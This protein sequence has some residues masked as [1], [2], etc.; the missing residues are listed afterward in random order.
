M[1]VR[2]II[3]AVH[4]LLTQ[5]GPTNKIKIVKLLY[6]A[7]KFHLMQYGRLITNDKYYAMEHGPV[8]SVTKDIFYP[9]NLSLSETEMEYSKKLIKDEDDHVFSAIDT[10]IEYDSLSETDIEV[11]NIIIRELGETEAWQLRDKTHEYPEW[12]KYEEQFNEKLTSRENIKTQ[13]L[14]SRIKGDLFDITDEHIEL[15]KAIFNGKLE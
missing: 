4:Y 9:S 1:S 2:T 8:G 12:K 11:L 13:E 6:F 5:L 14:F 15:S 7:D 10:D 3:Q